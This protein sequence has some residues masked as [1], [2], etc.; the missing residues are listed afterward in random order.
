MCTDD[1]YEHNVHTCNSSYRFVHK[2]S[3]KIGYCTLIA[4]IY[5]KREVF[6]ML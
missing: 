5:L 6:F 4:G 2:K 1:I 3:Q